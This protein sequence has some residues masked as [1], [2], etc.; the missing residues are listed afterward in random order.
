MIKSTRPTVLLLEDEVIIAIDIEDMLRE[1]G[2]VIG[3]SIDNCA[4]AL[5]WLSNNKPDIAIVDP[6]LKDGSC[7]RVVHQLIARN[8]PFV[9]Y[10]GDT[11]GAGSDDAAFQQGIQLGK[12][13]K[14]EEV[15]AA[16]V[17]ALSNRTTSPISGRSVL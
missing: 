7:G 4:E 17:S 12:P 8:I 6:R 10:S 13:S 16:M 5:I 11:Y 1:H 2:A 15:V 14:P 3:A 9:V